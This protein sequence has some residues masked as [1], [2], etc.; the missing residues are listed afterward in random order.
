MPHAKPSDEVA[1]NAAQVPIARY[2]SRMHER[3]HPIFAEQFLPALD[4]LPAS[5][6]LNAIDMS[7]NIEIILDGI[8]GHVIERG[9]I[10]SSGVT[11]FDI[12]V[13][14]SVER[15]SPFG[16]PPS[17]IVSP[18]GH[19]YMHWEFWRNPDFACSTYFTHPILLRT[20]S[21]SAPHESP[22]PSTTPRGGSEGR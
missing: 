14:D 2:L 21:D 8:D 7:T 15:A 4:K 16:V 1:L 20:A 22:V 3:I 12:G 13:L 6:P 17:E 18:D 10:K 9:V 19:V 11:A 5:S